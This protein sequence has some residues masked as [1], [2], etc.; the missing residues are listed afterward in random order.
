MLLQILKDIKE[1]L[2]SG[3]VPIS[4]LMK[5]C[6]IPLIPNKLEE[7]G[8]VENN[9]DS[10]HLTTTQYIN[11]LIKNQNTQIQLSTFT[12]F[13][14]SLFNIPSIKMG[15]TPIIFELRSRALI[16][17]NSDLYSKP[18][19]TGIRWIKTEY[20]FSKI[21][22]FNIRKIYK[23]SNSLDEYI[24]KLYN[25]LD[26]EG[27]KYLNKILKN[28]ETKYNEIIVDKYHILGAYAVNE[29]GKEQ[30]LRNNI[31]FLGYWP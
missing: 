1:G 20:P 24:D 29:I 8:Y 25:Y 14:K 11:P 7:L 4:Q 13:D 27:Y 23:E 26:I 18:D 12:K 15:G 10:Y 17:G 5:E 2:A 31:E 19:K 6:Y 28:K 9:F 22:F 3:F 16:E 21:L 30:I